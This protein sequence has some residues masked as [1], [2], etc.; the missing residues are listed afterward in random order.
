MRLVLIQQLI[1]T[2]NEFVVHYVTSTQLVSQNSSI[3]NNK[4]VAVKEFTLKTV[5][6]NYFRYFNI[7]RVCGT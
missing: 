6:V 2:S 7:K 4:P 3:F 1:L 5:G